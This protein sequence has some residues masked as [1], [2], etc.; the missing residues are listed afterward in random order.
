[1]HMKIKIPQTK[2]I[3]EKWG[4]YFAND[5]F[6][7]PLCSKRNGNSVIKKFFEQKFAKPSVVNLVPSIWFNEKNAIKKVRVELAFWYC[8][9]YALWLWYNA[10][11]LC[12]LISN[13]DFS[14]TLK[15]RFRN[16]PKKIAHFHSKWH[17]AHSDLYH[18]TTLL[19]TCFSSSSVKKDF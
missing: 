1:M 17:T 14:Y 2:V 6:C 5:H 18:H 13:A 4:Q 19:V 16:I 12:F 10:N 11:L 8:P 7:T 3:R 15:S 9:Y